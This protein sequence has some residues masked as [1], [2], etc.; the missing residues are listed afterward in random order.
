MEAVARKDTVFRSGRDRQLGGVS[1]L[2]G[3]FHA[4]GLAGAF[5]AL[6]EP[7]A[8]GRREAFG[9][10]VEAGLESAIGNGQGIVKFG[11]AREIAHAETIEPVERAGAALAA[12]NDLDDEFLRVHCVP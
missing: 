5:T 1:R 7:G 4:D 2:S 11:L 10:H 12:Y 6:G 8:E 3:N 9:G